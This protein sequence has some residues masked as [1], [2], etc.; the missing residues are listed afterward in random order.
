MNAIVSYD[1]TSNATPTA[2]TYG[3]LNRAYAFFNDRL[4]GNRLPDCLITLQ[5]HKGARGYFSPER[6]QSK[7]GEVVDEIALNPEHFGRTAREILS[8]LVHEM[9]HLEQ[10]HFG[11]PS[12]G[13]YH[14]KQWATFMK[15]VG[16]HPSDTAAPGG[17]ETGQFISHYIIEGGAYDVAFAEFEKGGFT[18]LFMDHT[19]E[20]EAAKKRR[21]KK[22][23]S[24]TPFECET[25]G[26]KAWAKP[27][28][29]LWC[30]ECQQPMICTAENEGDSEG[31]D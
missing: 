19:P 18:D 8:T 17:K 21:A 28:A 12:R 27:G 31:E 7:G 11:K 1:T 13:G 4:F 5:R 23:A 10:Q 22:N 15:A 2:A 9:T 30:G 16:L 3:D 14:N 25:C 6:F 26:L 20:G 29:S 24:K